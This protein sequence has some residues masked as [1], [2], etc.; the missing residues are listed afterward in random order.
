MITSKRN[1]V[2][3]GRGQGWHGQQGQEDLSRLDMEIGSI[4]G[5]NDLRCSAYCGVSFRYREA[6]EPF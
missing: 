1:V 5:H 6:N 4:M 2:L 3:G